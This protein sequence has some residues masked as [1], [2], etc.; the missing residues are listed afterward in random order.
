M[1]PGGD[2]APIAL[3]ETPNESLAQE[4][5]IEGSISPD[6]ANALAAATKAFERA[7]A[8]LDAIEKAATG[9]AKL[10]DSA[11]SVQEFL[12]T[13]DATGKKIG[14]LSD[15]VTTLDGSQSADE[16]EPTIQNLRQTIDEGEHDAGRADAREREDGRDEP[17]EWVGP[18][19][20]DSGADSARGDG[21]GC[22]LWDDDYDNA[23]ADLDPGQPDRLR[24]GTTDGGADRF[25]GQDN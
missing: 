9:V 4:L 15:D 16:I 22:A 2:G 5:I 1:L 23:G 24:G 19:G 10:S 14:G 3:S 7:G 13:W 25:D 12:A 6:P 17:G 21:P 8:T 20:S 18:T 11:G